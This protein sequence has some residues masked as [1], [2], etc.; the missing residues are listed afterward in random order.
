VLHQTVQFTAA[1]SAH[2]TGLRQ[3]AQIAARS[4]Y[5]LSLLTLVWGTLVSTGWVERLTGRQAMRSS[6]M[7]LATAAVGTGALH[8]LSFLYAED[9]EFTFFTLLFPASPDGQLRWTLGII[10]W[11]LMLAILISTGFVRFFIYRRWLWLHRLAYPAVGLIVLHSLL[12]AIRNGHLAELWLG[13]LT[14]FVPAALVTA[15]RVVPPG[16]LTRAGLVEEEL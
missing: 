7:M 14:L 4:S 6:H 15:L 13:G 9:Q 12:G 11:E 8:F 2:D 3:G 16:V 10:G 5:A 1:I